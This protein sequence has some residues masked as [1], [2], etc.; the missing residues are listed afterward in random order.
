MTT[1]TP[2]RKTPSYRQ[3]LKVVRALTPAEQLRLRDELAERLGVR[4]VRPATS[5]TAIRRGQRLAKA[6]R[7]ELAKAANG[8]LNKKRLN[9]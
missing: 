5:A 8:S 9:H 2:K 3:A 4:L 1:L 7:A 6:V